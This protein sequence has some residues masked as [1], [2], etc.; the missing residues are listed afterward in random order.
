MEAYSVWA[1]LNLKG[2]AEKK[3]K[4]FLMVTETTDKAFLRLNE[5]LGLFRAEINR[6]DLSLRVINPKM[7]KFMGM[8]KFIG[9]ESLTTTKSMD[10]LNRT[11]GRS[12]A[13]SDFLAN[14][15]NVVTNNLRKVSTEAIMAASSL[16]AMTAASR[17][18][19]EAGRVPIGI[20]SGSG[21]RGGSGGW[22]S[23]GGSHWGEVGAAGMARKVNFARGMGSNIALG[24]AAVAGM[25]LYE[26]YKENVNYEKGIGQ[27]RAQ[28]L[29]PAEI[30]QIRAF[31]SKNIAGI[32]P[33]KQM[34]ALLDAYMATGN[35][36]QAELLAPTL[37]KADF[38]SNSLYNGLTDDQLK[39]AVKMAEFRGGTDPEK[40]KKALQLILKLYTVSSGTL[41][42]SKVRSFNA[43][44]GG[45]GARISD[46]GMIALEP[47]LQEVQPSTLGYGLRTLNNKLV[48][49]IGVS[50]QSEAFF[51]KIG[52]W[53]K[54]DQLSPKMKELL[55]TDP[56]AFTQAVMSLFSKS[57]ITSAGD[58]Q[59]GLLEFGST[60]SLLM[61]TLNKNRTKS[62]LLRK[63]MGNLAGI[64]E[65][66][67]IALESESGAALRASQAFSSFAAALGKL[68]APGIIS[69]LNVLSSTFEKMA[70]GLNFMSDLAKKTPNIL[71]AGS[72]KTNAYI[73]SFVA[74]T[75][76]LGSTKEIPSSGK[77][78]SINV[79]TNVH[80]NGEVV[81][82]SVTNHM[83]DAM[84]RGG[85]QIM[86]NA[87]DP[88]QTAT[89]TALNGSG[90]FN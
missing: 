11:L 12:Y 66:T 86:A 40:I 57:G 3:M 81:G 54:K 87:Y 70:S 29:T 5:H 4:Q 85:T 30:K 35:L 53:N 8:L 56:E 47:S 7:Q 26:G 50:K 58:V 37:G 84:N 74:S 14:R 10:F 76:L 16:E 21:N 34:Q 38:I 90:G 2:D 82:K 25:G 80:L 27:F 24:T 88:Y 61:T 32:S 69:G 89:P 18:S 48:G 52:L 39:D 51:K 43:R 62:D 71:S 22:G 33:N 17:I 42:P 79:H 15:L 60:P 55:Q 45:A 1:T 41:D 72:A 23:H 9:S 68:T 49:H 77:N 19:A 63:R 59:S 73:Q 13:R 64:D 83:V 44:S 6:L 31:T 78:Q 75:D 65:E 36:S 20:R 46:A 28:G 67:R